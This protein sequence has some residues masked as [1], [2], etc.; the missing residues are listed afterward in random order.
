MGEY[1]KARCYYEKGI[2]ALERTGIYP[3][4]LHMWRVSLARSKVLNNDKDIKLDEILWHQEK[5]NLK[6]AGGWTKRHVGE[7]LLN[8]DDR[9]R[10]EAEDWVTKAIEL[11]KAN[12]TMWSLAGDYALYAELLKRK[13][14]PS[15]AKKNLAKA[16]DIFNECG[17]DGWVTKYER[18]LESIP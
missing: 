16:I 10:S 6:T 11:D 1:E 13:G 14:N 3:S 18:E 2:S 8:M 5:I 15:N 7:I 17:A 12:G 9:H 4:W